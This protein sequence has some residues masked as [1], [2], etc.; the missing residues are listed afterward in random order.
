MVNKDFNNKRF[1]DYND[2]SSEE[3]LIAKLQ[4][5][6]QNDKLGVEILMQPTFSA[7]KIKHNEQQQQV[8]EILSNII[9]SNEKPIAN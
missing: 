5:T 4:E 6:D 3:E 7:D 2:F 1:I 9:E 8:L